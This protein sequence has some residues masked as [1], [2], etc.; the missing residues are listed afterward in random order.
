MCL[1]VGAQNGVN[2]R[3]VAPL[4]PEPFEQVGIEP[5]GYNL[6]ATRQYNFRVLPEFVIRRVRVG[7]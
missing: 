3:L 5:H 7:V 6:F 4:L 2:A 1:H